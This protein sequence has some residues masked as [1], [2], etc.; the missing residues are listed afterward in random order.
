MYIFSVTKDMTKLIAR[1]KKPDGA[2]GRVTVYMDKALFK[3]FQ[4]L[5]GNVGVSAS[6]LIEE[7]VRDFVN[8]AESL[9]KKNAPETPKKK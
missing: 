8:D 1:I 7:M 9:P 3:Y 6:R 2:R 5:S 4:Q